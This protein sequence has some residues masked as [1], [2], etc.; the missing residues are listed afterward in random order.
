MSNS[1]RPCGLYVAYQ[2]SPSM[3]FSRQEYWNGLPFPSPGDLL[4]PGI[5][6]GS[7][8]LEADALTSEPQGSP[9]SLAT[10]C[11][12]YHKFLSLV[13]EILQSS[14]LTGPLGLLSSHC[15]WLT[16]EA[17]PQPCPLPLSL[18]LSC[19]GRAPRWGHLSPTWSV[20][21]LCTQAFTGILC[22]LHAAWPPGWVGLTI[23]QRA[24]VKS[25]GFVA[26]A[27]LVG[28]LG[29]QGASLELAS[30]CSSSRFLWTPAQCCPLIHVFVSLDHV[31]VCPGSMPHLHS[32]PK[33]DSSNSP[34]S[35]IVP[36]TQWELDKCLFG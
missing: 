19:R 20:S 21:S 36:G 15:P 12:V 18:C 7:L 16:H 32:T 25:S 30:E 17:S 10:A 3:G 5:E 2:A 4:D 28:G 24:L 35:R 13:F 8:V 31:A 22:I 14:E 23:F 11:R 6:L 1:L 26:A 27:E 33:L 9:I 29:W 34:A